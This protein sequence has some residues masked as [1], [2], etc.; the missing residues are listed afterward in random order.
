MITPRLFSLLLL[1][2]AVCGSTACSSSDKSSVVENIDVK[3]SHTELNFPIEGGQQEVQLEAPR[4]WSAFSDA[5]W[6][7]VSPKSSIEKKGTITINV[8]ANTSEGEPRTT[9]VT[10]RCGSLRKNIAIT[11]A[12]PE[13]KPIDTSI[14]TPEG[15]KL[16]WQEEFADAPSPLGLP[17]TV[18]TSR[19]RFENW[20]PGYVNNELQR[21][22]AG[23]V[24]DNDTT[25]SIKNGVLHITARKRS[26]EVISARMNSREA[27]LYGYFEARIKL[28]K[29][30]GTWPAYWMMP[31]DQSQGWPTCGEI[32][33]MEE[34]GYNPNY[35][36]SSIHC[37]DYNHT[38]GT[39]KTAERYTENAE[40]EFHVYALEWTEDYIQTY[41]DKRPLFRF[42][43]DK[44]GNN[45]TWPFNK[46][47]FIILNLAWGGMW[48]GQQGVDESALPATMEVDYVR[49]F[50]KP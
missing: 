6:V 20:A 45:A 47:F 36:S 25:A 12:A 24:M 14:D 44:K 4:E 46:K 17:A 41:V 29:G 32:D 18:S 43:N 35:T 27:W 19:W 39:Q 1:T 22:I 42:E 28:P 34:V 10:V 31:V 37:K 11:Q 7:D 49:V 33:I 26:A 16:V 15:Y 23:G 3:L 5:A 9:N 13:P 38:K 30:R 50:Q 21:Y 8:A 2:S 40:G 48:G